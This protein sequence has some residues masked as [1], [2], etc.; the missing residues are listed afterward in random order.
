MKRKLQ[1]PEA[2]YPLGHPA[3][4]SKKRKFP[5]VLRA[6]HWYGHKGGKFANKILLARGTLLALSNAQDVP[7]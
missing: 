7:T 1:T 3:D 4:H 5:A 2:S 6:A